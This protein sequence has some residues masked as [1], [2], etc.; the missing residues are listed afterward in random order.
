MVFIK[1]SHS[2]QILIEKKKEISQGKTFEKVISE[3]IENHKDV[4]FYD[5][6]ADKNPIRDALVL[7]QNGLCAYCMEKLLLQV[8]K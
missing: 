1:K 4:D 6:I 2:P 5:E 8:R 3:L 7:E